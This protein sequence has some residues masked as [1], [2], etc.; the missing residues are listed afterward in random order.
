MGLPCFGGDDG[1]GDSTMSNN[2]I[3]IRRAMEITATIALMKAPI[4]I[5]VISCMYLCMCC[6]LLSFPLSS[7][8]GGKEGE[9]EGERKGI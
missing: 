6:V 8:G 1:A 2:N 3:V 7:K 9:E 5:H 4:I